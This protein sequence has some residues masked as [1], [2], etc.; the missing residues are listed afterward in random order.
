[1]DRQQLIDAGLFHSI[2]TSERKAF[3]ACRRRWNWSYRQ[4]FHPTVMPKPLEFGIAWHV[5]METWYNPDT[6]KTDRKLAYAK[7]V[8]IFMKTLDDQLKRYEEL[9]GTPDDE[10]LQDYLERRTLG[11]KMIDYYCLRISP[12]LDK[13]LT[14][15]AVEIP[16]EVDMEFD[17]KCNRCWDL[18]VNFEL[19]N[20]KSWTSIRKRSEDAGSIGAMDEWRSEWKGLPVTFGGRIDAIFQ[21]SEG[22]ILVFDWKTTA[23][24][25]DGEDEAAFLQLDDQVGGYPVAL[26]K[27]GRQVDG[28]IYHEQKKAIPEPPEQLKRMYKGKMFSTGKDKNVEYTTFL[29]TIMK[30]D[31]YAYNNGLYD[32][33]LE[34]LMGPMAPKFYQRHTI[35]K[36]DTQMNNFWEDLK[37]EAEDMLQNPNVYP[38]ASRF[39]CNSC[40]YRQPCEAKNRGEDAQ[41]LLDTMF[42][43]DKS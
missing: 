4:G 16:F 19:K 39:S 29:N 17:C 7:T 15:L 33:Y 32:E 30:E 13:D 14:P 11:L 34:Y 40:L 10:T 2:H 31:L 25:L 27:L 12:L 26:Y 21:D 9:N 6:W 20:D 8:G 5:A 35:L 43:K 24:I 38:Q 1:M 28:F 36:T 18:F 37:L 3:R 41:Y 23:R 42:T 22:R